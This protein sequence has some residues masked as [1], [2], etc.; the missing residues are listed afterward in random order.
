M[1]SEVISPSQEPSVPLRIRAAEALHAQ[2]AGPTAL[3]LFSTAFA[4][5]AALLLLVNHPGMAAIL[6][7][8]SLI[9]SELAAVPAGP[10][11]RDVRTIVRAVNPLLGLLFV[12]GI[13]GG[14]ATQA[15]PVLRALAL[16]VFLLEAWL[17]ILRAVAG[18]LRMTDE[19]SLWTRADR[20]AVLLLGA[21]I[22]RIGPS[23]LFVAAIGILDAWFRVERLDLP[24]GV[25]PEVEISWLRHVVREDGSFVPVVRWTTLAL[26]AMALF[27]L[28]AGA[29]WRF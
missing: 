19:T 23:L 12:A 21:F 6:G 9:G 29:T 24:A 8:V 22:G 10:A 14:P 5:A 25:K 2:G 15:S 4:V 7:L 20:L 13:V 17:P 27:L 26:A 16:V 28:P 11:F 1:P 18:P 3:L